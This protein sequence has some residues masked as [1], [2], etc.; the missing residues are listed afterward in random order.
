MSETFHPPNEDLR[1]QY[2][3]R[4]DI[5][6][7]GTSGPIQVSYSTDYSAS[8]GLWHRTL[9][10]L[11]VQT[12]P[13]HL[14]GSNV[15]VWTNVNTVDPR[16]ARRSYSSGY[17]ASSRSNLHILTHATVHEVVIEQGSVNGEMVA[18]GV[19]FT[20]QDQE[21]TAS[22]N[23][24]IILSAGS[25]QSPQILE[26]SG[27][28]DPQ[29]LNKAG[30]P[31]KVD[32]PN[33]G[34]NL[35]EHLS[36]NDISFAIIWTYNEFTRANQSAVLALIV[37]V[38]PSLANP[39]DLNKDESYA[40]T[41]KEQYVRAQTGPLTILPCSISYVSFAQFMPSNLLSA[42]ASRA[43][44][45][46]EY[47]SAKNDILTKRLDG[48]AT[49]GQI[50][51]IFDLGNWSPSFKGIQGKKYG[52]LLQILQYPFSVGSIH[53]KPRIGDETPTRQGGQRKPLID[54]RYYDGLNGELD[55]EVM[56]ECLHF[57]S[58]I[59]TTAPLSDIIRAA[60]DPPA[61]TLEN[62]VLLKQWITDRTITDWHPVGTCAMGGR[63]GIQ[64][65][66]VD[67]RLRVYGVKGLRV[68]D[69]SVMPL[70]ISAH[71]QATIY[72]IGEK[73]AHM[74][75]RDQEVIS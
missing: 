4:H 47:S 2:D 29:V 72:A 68:A 34:E 31:V 51:Y 19:R 26:L 61:P 32:S 52:T 38:D 23:R 17:C 15:G 50:E 6:A 43:A 54:P 33:V 70:Q 62:Q 16:T 49:L 37:E 58:K 8:H 45:L 57:A 22:A 9:N 48:N 69:A 67:A 28:G 11:G 66:V 10:A 74:I 59:I 53:V 75:L 41:A 55:L 7:F 25:V 1:E 44:T 35:Q 27:I 14:A 56:Q 12:N 18:T 30:I 42:L 21:Y 20:C 64:D 5:E 24:E 13:A 40:A 36:E 65:G 63:D 71:P 3:V 60:A 73:A 39:D 46:T